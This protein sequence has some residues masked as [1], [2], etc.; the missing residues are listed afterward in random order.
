[1][2]HEIAKQDLQVYLQ[3]CKERWNKEMEDSERIRLPTQWPKCIGIWTSGERSFLDQLRRRG[4]RFDARLFT[5]VV[6]DAHLDQK[7]RKTNVTF[8]LDYKCPM[9]DQTITAAAGLQGFR[10]LVSPELGGLV[11]HDAGVQGPHHIL[12]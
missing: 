11:A 10:S 5:T 7:A 8:L 4:H 6:L 2:A 9:D 12:R 3:T 1:M